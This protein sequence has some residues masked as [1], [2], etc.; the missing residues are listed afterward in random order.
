[1]LLFL[2]LFRL[3]V[4]AGCLLLG[5]L[6]VNFSNN[7]FFFFGVWGYWAYYTLHYA[8]AELNPLFFHD[9]NAWHLHDLYAQ[10]FHELD[11]GHFS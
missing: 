6:A 4:S 9:S 7:S 10:P 2:F 3:Y 1:M 5:L 8:I 11:A